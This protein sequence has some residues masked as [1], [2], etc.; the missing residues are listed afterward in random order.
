MNDLAQNKIVRLRQLVKSLTMMARA[1]LMG[2]LR[3][4]GHLVRIFA[5]HA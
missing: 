1:D 2:N 3:A 5:A 4:E